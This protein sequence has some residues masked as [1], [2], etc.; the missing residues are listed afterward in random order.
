[1]FAP[2]RSLYAF[3]PHASRGVLAATASVTVVFAATPFLV[4]ETAARLGVSLG[5]SGLLSTF[6]VGAFALASMAGARLW[7][8][9]ARLLY[10]AGAVLALANLASA[11]TGTFEVLLGLRALSGGAAGI[12]T[13]I[14]WVEA[15]R[16]PRGIGDVA[17]IG[18]LTGML[19]SPLLGWAGQAGGDRAIFLLL[20]L[21]GAAGLTVPARLEAE[22]GSP[23]R[24][25]KASRSN[26]LL[27]VALLLLTL[28]GS[29]LFVYAAAL[30]QRVSGM[31]PVAVSGA[32]ALNAAVGIVATR[33]RAGAGRG[34]LWLAGTALSP[35]GMVLVPG[36][37][38]FYL[39]MTW[40]GFAFW[41]GL[42]EVFRLLEA[43]S[44]RVGER[45]GDAHGLMALGRA[46]G[47]A[48]GGVLV[49]EAEF[50]ALGIFAA[51]GVILAALAIGVVEAYR[52]R[53]AAMAS[54][55]SAA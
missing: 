7:A 3:R 38:V 21:V 10:V 44:S 54:S 16:H 17:A 5:T 46:V 45:M 51:G 11:L 53:Y 34:G 13:W 48:V 12:M 8:P 6:Q 15:A 41:V 4:P 14:A 35:L 29:S 19:A 43:R 27:L 33:L 9:S 49:G 25:P 42:P 23:L 24:H 1:M 31:S 18:P 20:A 37:A 50:L 26:R 30:A 39:A 32:F 40:W 47:P 52:V 55:T 36:P 28:A 2:L 22:G